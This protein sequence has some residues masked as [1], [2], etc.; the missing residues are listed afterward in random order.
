M[1][2]LTKSNYYGTL[3]FGSKAPTAGSKYDHRNAPVGGPLPWRFNTGTLAFLML[4]ALA[5]LTALHGKDAQT[6][7]SDQEMATTSTSLS[8]D[9]Y[10]EVYS[11]TD[12][13]DDGGVSYYAHSSYVIY[14]ADG[15]RFKTVENHISPSDET[16]DLVSLP[17]GI[18]TV[19]ARSETRGYIRLRVIVKRGR[20]T[21]LDL[22]SEQAPAFAQEA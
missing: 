10:L 11:A 14:T 6:G 4:V 5:L 2:S 9:G 3:R 7:E 8:S 19:E 17:A 20:V 12:E 16:P 22:E 1:N 15:K 13:Y 21:V 18:Y